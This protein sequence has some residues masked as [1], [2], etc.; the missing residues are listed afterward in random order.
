MSVFLLGFF[1][2]FFFLSVI[3]FIHDYRIPLFY[4]GSFFNNLW[5]CIWERLLLYCYFIGLFFFV[6]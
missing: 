6:T 3:T 2:S 4:L 1:F 5:F